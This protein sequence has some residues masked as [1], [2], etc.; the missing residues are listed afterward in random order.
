MFID[1]VLYPIESLGPGKRVAIWLVGCSRGCKGCSNP[2]LWSVEGRRSVPVSAILQTIQDIHQ[3][4]QIDGFTITGG[5]PMEQAEELLALILG[6]H[7]ISKD[8]LVFSGYRIEELLERRGAFSTVLEHIAVLVDGPYCEDLNEQL[9]LRGS[10]NQRVLLLNTVFA[11]RYADYLRQE[12][13]TVQN[14][15]FDGETT[16]VGIHR[17][18]FRDELEKKLQKQGIRSGERG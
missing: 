5:E 15:H 1:Q 11:D 4:N 7:Q 6:L 16:S 10:L 14:V 9:P 13:S 2:E 18:D 17:K 3:E 12:H 8:I